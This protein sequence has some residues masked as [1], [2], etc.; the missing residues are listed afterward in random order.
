[1]AAHSHSC[2]IQRIDQFV[3]APVASA[4]V[5]WGNPGVAPATGPSAGTFKSPLPR[6]EML[7]RIREKLRSE[8]PST[9]VADAGGYKMEPCR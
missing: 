5:P 9:T 3:V 6:V 7:K 8:E 1:V 2:A 4:G